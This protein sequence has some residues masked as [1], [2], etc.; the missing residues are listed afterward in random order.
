M[1]RPQEAGTGIVNLPDEDPYAV[2]VMMHYF[3]H[4]DYPKTLPY[5]YEAPPSPPA[6]APVSPAIISNPTS[7]L[8]EPAP[9]SPQDVPNTEASGADP[10]DDPW[11][12]ELRKK[13]KKKTKKENM[14]FWGVTD[15]PDAPARLS[16][17]SPS[18]GLALHAKVFALAEMHLVKDLKDLA[19]LKFRREANTNWEPDDFLLA[20]EIAYV[21]TAEE[22][23][24]LREAVL[25]VF[26]AHRT[27]LKTD[28]CRS[29]LKRLPDLSYD[30][31]LHVH[32]LDSLGSRAEE[33]AKQ[34]TF[35]GPSPSESVIW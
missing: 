30:M 29:L 9:A 17:P 8:A 27:L 2:E 21:G 31:L 10:L 7:D 28:E 25:D 4:L 18:L 23:R 34:V 20:A 11:F 3:Y 16:S 15:P 33:K 1:Q 5:F 26:Q 14:S 19:L 35:T 13:K 24:E 12:P 6:A 22:I 32:G